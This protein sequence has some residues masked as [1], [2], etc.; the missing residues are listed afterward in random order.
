MKLSGKVHF[1]QWS[2]FSS[3]YGTRARTT[4]MPN[5]ALGGMM[6]PGTGTAFLCAFKS[7]GLAFG[8]FNVSTA[9]GIAFLYWRTGDCSIG[10]ENAAIAR[11]WLKQR[12]ATLA[13]IKPLASVG[14]HGF[15]LH[16]ATFRARDRGLQFYVDFLRRHN[17]TPIIIKNIAKAG[18]R[19]K[20]L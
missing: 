16:V 14:R 13:I 15:D 7:G 12:I 11:F 9:A 10:A 6:F 4:S 1:E 18:S 3:V 2:D 5:Q 19:T 8:Q 20:S 17:A